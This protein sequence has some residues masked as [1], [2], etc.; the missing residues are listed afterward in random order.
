MEAY[1]V[2]A[3]NGI[4]LMQIINRPKWWILVTF[5]PLSIY[6]ISNHLIETLRT[7]GKKSTVDMVLG[8]VTFRFYIACV[9]YK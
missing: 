1:F 4:V 7:F 5:I 3:Y 2:P 9:N 6:F 8:V